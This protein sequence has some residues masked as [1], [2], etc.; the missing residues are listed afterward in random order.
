[1][2]AVLQSCETADNKD[3][4]AH[5]LAETLLLST[6]KQAQSDEVVLEKGD[7]KGFD[8]SKSYLEESLP[9]RGRYDLL[10]NVTDVCGTKYRTQEIRDFRRPIDN[11]TIALFF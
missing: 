2:S 8:D 4:T 5:K 6:P 9:K 7:S 10:L 1:M 11:V 3:V